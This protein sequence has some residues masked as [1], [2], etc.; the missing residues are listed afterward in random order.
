LEGSAFV[1]GKD[2]N[3]VFTSFECLLEYATILNLSGPNALLPFSEGHAAARL[4][5]TYICNAFQDVVLVE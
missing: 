2:E 4:V 5:R 3:N 1:D